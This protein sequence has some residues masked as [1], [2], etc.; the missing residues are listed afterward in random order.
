MRDIDYPVYDVLVIGGGASGMMAAICAAGQGASVCILER[1]ARVGKK[2]LSTGNGKCNYTNDAWGESC[3]H[4][5]APG[6]AM[7]VVRRFPPHKTMAFFEELGIL[8]YSRDGYVYPRSRQAASMVS[9]L[10][11]ELERTNVCVMVSETMRK[12]EK[13]DGVFWA[14]TKTGGIY[15][16]TCI[17]AAGGKAA[18]ATGSDGSGYTYARAFGHTIV[19]P[20]PALVPLRSVDVGLKSMAGSRVMA[21]VALYVSG[22]LAAKEYGEVQLTKEGISGIPVF[23]VSRFASRGLAD[24]QEV[25][26]RVGFAPELSFDE[27]R[28]EICRRCRRGWGRLTAGEALVGWFPKNVAGALLQKAGIAISLPVSV[29]TD[30]QK[31]ALA[32]TIKQYVFPIHATMGFERAQV[33]AGGVQTREID[34]ATME[35]KICGGLYFAGEIVDVDGICGGYNLQWAWSSG[36]LAGIHAA[37]RSV[38]DDNG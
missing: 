6:F 35:S 29:L 27:V 36:Y 17:L 23:Q 26:A 16:R 15:G 18:P 1:G 32:E 14:E 31:N 5:G 10:C 13:A 38:E 11:M 25:E 28:G 33:T 8:P 19:P 21:E 34:A 12:L 22:S 24:R 7:S 37:G 20:V 30:A 9:A 4:G 3:Y 2:I